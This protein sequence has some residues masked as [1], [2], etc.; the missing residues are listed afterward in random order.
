[1]LHQRL[2][3]PQRTVA[4]TADRAEAIRAVAGRRLRADPVRR[5]GLPERGGAPYPQD[6]RGVSPLVSALDS[7]ALRRLMGLMDEIVPALISLF[8]CI[9]EPRI[10]TSSRNARVGFVRV[11]PA[12]PGRWRAGMS[13]N[14]GNMSE[15][16]PPVVVALGKDK[17]F[18][19][20]GSPASQKLNQD[21]SDTGCSGT[22]VVPAA[23]CTRGSGP[24][25]LGEWCR[26]V[27]LR[28]RCLPTG[29]RDRG[30]TLLKIGLSA[31]TFDPSTSTSR[32]PGS[33]S[34]QP[35]RSS[36]CGRR[37]LSPTWRNAAS[38][39]PMVSLPG[40]A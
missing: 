34:R 27:S 37:F 22:A 30:E 11:T 28:R 39:S 9:A 4:P 17:G 35:S 36:T 12:P 2:P 10:V 1:M 24:R 13:E 8:S 26:G 25:R 31:N 16:L 19:F 14:R 20:A 18:L 3:E 29:D 5:R 40:R 21:L 33:G 38:W 23:P 7:R 6:A 15:S 32:S